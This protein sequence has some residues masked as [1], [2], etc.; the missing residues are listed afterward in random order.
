MLPG[1]VYGVIPPIGS[2]TKGPRGLFFHPIIHSIKLLNLN[3]NHTSR[4]SQISTAESLHLQ[5]PLRVSSLKMYSVQLITLISTF[6]AARWAW[7]FL[8]NWW[9]TR[10]QFSALANTSC[11]CQYK[12]NNPTYICCYLQIYEGL[13]NDITYSASDIQVCHNYFHGSQTV[14]DFKKQ[15]QKVQ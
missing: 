13:P 3:F 4:T 12:P 2:D 11:Q 10:I 6:F 14:T 9:I 1:G 7:L 8:I 15:N 5:L